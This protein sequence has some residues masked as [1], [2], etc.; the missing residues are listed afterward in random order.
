[1][2]TDRHRQLLRHDADP[3]RRRPR[4]PSRRRECARCRSGALALGAAFQGRPGGHRAPGEHQ[5][6]TLHRGWRDRARLP[7][8]DSRT[9]LRVLGAARNVSGNPPVR[10]RE[11]GQS[12]V[13]TGPLV[14]VAHGPTQRRGRARTCA[15][16]PQYG[17][18]PNARRAQTRPRPA[19]SAVSRNRRG[20]S[21]WPQAGGID[22]RHPN[23]GL[24]HGVAD[25]V[26]TS[27]IYCWR[28]R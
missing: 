16:D 11:G 12:D 5:W 17:G 3:I 8:R 26:R 10:L 27:R 28:E 20:H 15:D 4:I 19:R 13:V 1:M 21:G 14:A 25:C 7:R 18:S 6:W 23:D 24:W 2:G 22:A 9:A